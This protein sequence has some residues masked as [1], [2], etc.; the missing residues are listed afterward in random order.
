MSLLYKPKEEQTTSC[1]IKQEDG[2]IVL[3][4]YCDCGKF[5]TDEMLDGYKLTPERLLQILQGGICGVIKQGKVSFWKRM[6]AVAANGRGYVQLPLVET[7]N[8]ALN[9]MGQLHIAFVMP[10]F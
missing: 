1:E 10:R 9:F 5:G 4:F 6:V 8:I 7:F 2:K 3:D